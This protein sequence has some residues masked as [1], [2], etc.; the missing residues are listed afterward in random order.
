MSN[1]AVAIKQPQRRAQL[2]LRG[3]SGILALLFAG[4]GWL[5][6]TAAS[7]AP[8]SEAFWSAVIG[9]LVGGFL[10]ILGGAVLVWVQRLHDD[11]RAN[12]E[13]ETAALMVSDEL[14]ANIVRLEIAQ[15]ANE[16]PD[17]LR[18]VIYLKQQM[19]IVPRI[20]RETCDAVRGYYPAPWTTLAEGG[21]AL[22]HH[23]LNTARWRTPK[24]PSLG[25][26]N[27]C[28]DSI[29]HSLG[30]LSE[31]SVRAFPETCHRSGLSTC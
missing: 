1:A 18:N 16:V 10:S 25:R 23:R 22:S 9:A 2:L 14:R 4:L 30:I 5:A 26:R 24:P 17:D 31:F 7:K 11:W 28:P 13:F 6:Y 15:L 12:E 21:H 19:V 3:G 8:H 29:Q 20:D 27:S